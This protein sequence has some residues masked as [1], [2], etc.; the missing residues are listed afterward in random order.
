[1]NKIR[2][3][4]FTAF[5]FALPGFFAGAQAAQDGSSSELPLRR[6]ALFSSGV[7]FFEHSGNVA[8]HTGGINLP[9]DAGAVNDVLKSLVVN[10]PASTSISVRY[11]SENT[12]WRTLRSLQVD[13]SGSP[14]IA[15]ILNGLRGAELEVT[16]PNPI[17]GRIVGV[18]YRH[19]S[20]SMGGQ[21]WFPPMMPTAEAWLSLF[22]QQGIRVIPIRDIA[23]FRFIDEMINSDLNRA[24]DLIM[25]ARDETTRNLLV[26]MDGRENRNVSIS[27]VI[28]APVW[29]VSY[30]LDL[31]GEEPFLQG[32]AIVD[33]DSDTDW[34]DVELSLVIGR[35]VSFIQNLFPTYHVFRPVVP[36]SV[37]GVAEGR[38]HE[39]GFGFRVAEQELSNLMM[40]GMAE[41]EMMTDQGRDARW[42]APTAVPQAAAPGIAAGQIQ[43]AAPVTA[44]DQFLFTLRNPV[45]LDRR[46]SAMLPLVE[47]T[48]QAERTLVFSGARALSGQTINPEMSAE[49]TNTSGMRLPAG[50]ITVF[51]GS[52]Y[53]GDALLEF[54]PENERRLISFGE[55]LSV[56]GSLTQSSS[57]NITTVNISGGV[58]T[59]RRRLNHERSYTIRNASDEAKRIIIEHPITAGA[60]LTEPRNAD[61]RTATLYRFNRN[62]PARG[63][64][65]FNVREETPL[66]ENITLAPL[67]PEA[68]LSFATNQE[69]PAN[70]RAALSRAIELRRTA[71]E[72][73]ST[74]TLLE[75]QLTR[76][77]TEQDRVRRNLEAAGNQTPQGQEYLRR[78]A[79]LD[80]DIDSLNSRIDAAIQETQRTRREF[81]N[82]LATISI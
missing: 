61:D 81:E 21:Q 48:V 36:L 72:A 28:A 35:P 56:T 49:L 53:A 20:A 4:L 15:E 23:T 30:R 2:L 19:S 16:A 31:S 44:G 55:D 3:F 1:M 40:R 9:F 71:D 65:T 24:L 18:E 51:D 10:D 5:C 54:F 32:W 22:T 75:S 33:N 79:A 64:I 67:R 38:A 70:V 27:Y 43:T 34:K 68:L 63:T 80:N 46:Q 62:L 76:L 69:I 66:S 73:A 82:Y 77:V 26:T 11:A 14:G 13:L 52:I 37:P 58:M 42:A 17:R 39:G 6:V 41:M 29:K 45:S 74:Q 25:T 78:L 59:I 12:L 7:G 8:P 60:E 57:R 47:G 50:P